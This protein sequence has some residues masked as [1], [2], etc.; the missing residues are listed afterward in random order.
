[1]HLPSLIQRLKERK[2]VQWTLGYL[3]GA[4]VCLEAFDIV[5][6][7]FQWA[8]WVRQGVTVALMFGFLVTLVLAWHHGE[9]GRQQVSLGELA[10]VVLL[11]ALAGVSLLALRGRSQDQA[12]MSAAGMS[13]GF[14]RDTPHERSVAVLPCTDMSQQGDQ[15]YFADGLADEMTTRL[16][17][18][19]DLRVASRTSAFSF[20]DS[21][22]GIGTI[23]AALKVR[24]I[25]S[26]G[27]RRDGNQVRITANLVD[28]EEGFERW[29]A[30]FDSDL[31]NILAVQE[32]I[33]LAIAEALEAELGV[34]ERSRLAARGTEN[35]EA[36]DLYLRGI[37]YQWRQPWSSENQSRALDLFQAAVE[38]DPTFAAA[39]ALL[40]TSY[41]SLGNFHVIPPEEAYS[42]AEVAANRAVALDNDLAHAHWALGWVKFAY[43]FDW[44]GGEE[45][46]RRT[47]ALAPNDFTGYHSLT[48]PL[49]VFGK[50]EEAKAAAEEAISLDPLAVWP[51]IGLFEVRFKMGDFSGMI[52]DAEASLAFEPNDPLSLINLALARAHTGAFPEAVSAA[53]EA[54][55]L[56]PGDPWVILTAA[57]VFAIVGD[58]AAARDR[59][60]TMENAVAEGVTNVSPGNLAV[61]Y[62]SLGDAD[63]VFDLLNLVIDTFDPGAFSLNYPEFRP[64]WGD[65]RFGDLLDRLGLPREA[66][67]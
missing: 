24:N 15:E 6:E 45:E 40:A 27:V 63:R 1:M 49:S 13:F 50:F 65:A 66:Y 18:I 54:E 48:F 34:N 60:A 23:A 52:A 7:Q 43:H 51:R 5:A 4:F 11:L 64:Y 61:V 62:A 31:G 25:L 33:A 22:E 35:Q 16:G 38:V 17:A 32:E 29:S 21:G 30:S 41:V 20:K 55:S 26:C 46:F 12:A 42:K 10:S 67:R 44:K 2:L 39:W 8:L 28:A 57:N 36:Y 47:I 53:V 59:L 58:V 14:R 19:H 37:S 9:K 3:A 56:A